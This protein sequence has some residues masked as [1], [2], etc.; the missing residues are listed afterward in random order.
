VIE[1]LQEEVAP[2]LALYKGRL[3][4]ANVQLQV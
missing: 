4:D 2:V 1:F 3:G